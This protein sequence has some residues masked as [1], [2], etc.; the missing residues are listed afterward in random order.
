MAIHAST[1]CLKGVVDLYRKVRV[2]RMLWYYRSE[3]RK[4]SGFAFDCPENELRGISKV[5]IM[6]MMK[7]LIP[8]II[9]YLLRAEKQEIFS[10][11]GRVVILCYSLI[12]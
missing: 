2:V 1:S 8:R 9:M 6:L 7:V 3:V 5:N 10:E 4:S 12:M 11:R